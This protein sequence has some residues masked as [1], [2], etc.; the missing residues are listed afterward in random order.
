MQEI[1]HLQITTT[2]KYSI[3]KPWLIW[4]S[5]ALFVLFQFF[6]QLSS[7]V[8]VEDLMR[9]FTINALGAG[10]LSSTYYYVYVTLQTPAGI[11]IDRYG[12]RKLLT[13]G[14]FVCAV[15]C[16]LFATASHL[17]L[18]EVGRLLMGAG[19]AFAFVGSLF[20]INQ[21]FPVERFALMVGIAETVGTIGTIIGNVFLATALN[22]FGWRHCMMVATILAIIIG[23]ACWLII[24]DRPESISEYEIY[25]SKEEGF[26]KHAI[27]L[28]RNP[29]AWLNGIY[30]GLMFSVVTVFVALW[31]I[32][33]LVKSHAISITM[34]TILGSFLFLGLAIGC[35][36]I[37]IF[38]DRVKNRKALMFLCALLSAVIL[39]LI[40][41]ITT[42]PIFVVSLMMLVLGILCSC[43]VINFAIAKEIAPD[44]ATSTSIGFTN[45]LSVITAPLLQPIIGG[46]L[47]WVHHSV[48]G[49]NAG[50]Y[51][52]F[53]FQVALM[54]L[55]LCL[56]AAAIMALYI[57]KNEMA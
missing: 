19:S 38:C 33:F 24:R 57:E 53:D 7:G 6:L 13:A 39:A 28:L 5:S 34:A 43:Y 36:L 9:S 12:P 27:T 17:A 26:L 29:K 20:L 48:S 49:T 50:T 1:D 42:L 18:A 51:N 3:L 14:A 8:I 47:H 16:W 21:W 2:K 11:L 41:V 54:T 25:H 23:L 30:S 44:E 45:T 40:I 52:V 55:P 15:G 35:P 31:G 4:G 37:G 46:L 22:N 56:V 32:P 10:I